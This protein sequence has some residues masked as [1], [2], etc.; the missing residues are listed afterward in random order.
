[1]PRR[2][3]QSLPGQT[4]LASALKAKSGPRKQPAA[5][6]RFAWSSSCGVPLGLA[7]FGFSSP[8]GISK[9]IRENRN[10]APPEP[11]RVRGKV[12]Q[13]T[14]VTRP[15]VVAA[16]ALE[17]RGPVAADLWSQWACEIGGRGS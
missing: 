12:T 2:H 3:S 7:H 17:S 11:Q 8:S 10:A 1:S 9:G 5:H 16:A 4:L 14:R 13:Q 15:G 6:Q